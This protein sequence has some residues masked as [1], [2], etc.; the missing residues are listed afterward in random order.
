MQRQYQTLFVRDFGV[1]INWI[2][3]KSKQHCNTALNKISIN[4]ESMKNAVF[5]TPGN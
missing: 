5:E 2:I 1:M 3:M 4:H